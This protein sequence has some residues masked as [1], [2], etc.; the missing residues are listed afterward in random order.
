MN[1]NLE[2]KELSDKALYARKVFLSDLE[3]LPQACQATVNNLYKSRIENQNEAPLLGECAP[4][5]LSDILSIPTPRTAEKILPPWMS[6]YVHTILLDD[7]LDNNDRRVVAPTLIASSLIAERGIRQLYEIFPDNSWIFLKLDEC[8]LEM[9]AAAINEIQN[10]RNSLQKYSKRDVDE[11]GKKFSLL[12]LC[13]AMLLA[14]SNKIAPPS[15]IFLPVSLLSS[16]MQLLDDITDFFDD[17]K[18]NN[19]T[20]LLT[21]TLLFL[22]KLPRKNFRQDLILAEM[23]RDQVIA[24]MII[25][26]SLENYLLK[27]KQILT[28]MINLSSDKNQT[29]THIF[30]SLLISEID[31]F[32]LLV[33]QA[34]KTIKQ[35]AIP[36]KFFWPEIYTPDENIM[37]WVKEIDRG[38]KIIAQGC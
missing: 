35:K 30:F 1:T 20:P 6:L 10:H 28:K 18:I 16:G 2:L 11:I 12:N 36:D 24:A 26:G 33:M 23:R 22:N 9:A 4:W 13:G 8:F 37:N 17:W 38:I 14:D 25:S 34:H 19:Y 31:G 29:S 32:R 27:A 3:N 5:M 21:D 7:I 15:K